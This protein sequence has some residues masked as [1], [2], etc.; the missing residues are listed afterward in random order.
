MKTSHNCRGKSKTFLQA[1][2]LTAAVGCVLFFAVFATK[3]PYQVTAAH[4]A[5]NKPCKKT[6]VSLQDRYLEAENAFH[7]ACGKCHVPPDPSKP[8][9]ASN[10]NEEDLTAIWN[11][12]YETRTL[13]TAALDCLES[14]GR[15]TYERHC[16]KCHKL[17]EPTKP[18]CLSETPL[19][20]LIKAHSF[21]ESVREGKDLYGKGCNNCHASIEPS[22]HSFDFWRRHLCA[23]ATGLEMDEAQKVLL[24]LK[25]S[26]NRQ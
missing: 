5:E 6:A 19:A 8:S 26:G 1:I 16:S 11:Y 25:A 15:G 23:E 4:A 14:E 13:G 22:K 17:P 3:S 2:A 24:Y 7:E 18:N 10:L 21:M 12:M 9:C 20:E